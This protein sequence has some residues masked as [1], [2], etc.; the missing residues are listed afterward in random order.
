M[1]LGPRVTVIGRGTREST[2]AWVTTGIAWVRWGVPGVLGL[3]GTVVSE[4]PTSASNG[5]ELMELCLS[6]LGIGSPILPPTEV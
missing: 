6:G 1:D 4:R 3:P 2:G 5:Q